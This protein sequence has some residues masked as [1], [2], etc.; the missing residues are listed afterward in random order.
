MRCSAG[1]PHRRSTSGHAAAALSTSPSSTRAA[2]RAS[3]CAYSCARVPAGTLDGSASDIATPDEEDEGG[4]D[5]IR[6]VTPCHGSV[7]E[8]RKDTAPVARIV[9]DDH[10]RNRDAARRIDAPSAGRTTGITGGTGSL[11]S[12]RRVRALV[13]M[14]TPSHQ[15]SGVGTGS[16][17]RNSSFERPN[18]SRNRPMTCICVE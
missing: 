15:Q 4:E 5:Q 13:A 10:A 17:S 18:A 3:R 8:L 16:P 11:R 1:D 6:G 9:H 7:R 2:P 14:F 12:F